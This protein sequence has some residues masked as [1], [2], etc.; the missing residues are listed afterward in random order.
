[1]S[2]EEKRRIIGGIIYGIAVGL[3]FV[4]EALGVRRVG[5]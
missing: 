4:A 5:S 2:D 1:M 3:V